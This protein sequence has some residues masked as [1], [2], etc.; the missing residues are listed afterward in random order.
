MKSDLVCQPGV[1]KEGRIATP[2]RS[3]VFFY[4][5]DLADKFA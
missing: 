3:R 2:P 5:G 1:A 4:R